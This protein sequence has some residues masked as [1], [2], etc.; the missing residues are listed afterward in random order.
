MTRSSFLFLQDE[1][2]KWY[3]TM[4]HDESSNTR[5]GGNDDTATNKE[6]LGRMY[7]TDHQMMDLIFQFP[8]QYWKGPEESVWFK[9]LH[10]GVNNLGSMMKELSKAANL[11]QVYS[12]HCIRETAK[13]MWSVDGLSSHHNM[14][15]CGHRN[16]DSLKSYNTRL[17]S[18]QLQVCSNVLS[19]ALNPQ[20]DQKMKVQQEHQHPRSGSC[21]A[22]PAQPNL[23]R[24]DVERFTFSMM[25]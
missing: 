24:H 6:K 20:S 11:S 1:N 7:Q 25:F 2:N 14:R 16:E 3:T 19:S 10:L 23:I 17:L 12:N 4:A 8:K 21:A 18:Q 22:F 9:N 15:L 5:Q 13:K